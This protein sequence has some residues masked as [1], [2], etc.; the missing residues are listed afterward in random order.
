SVL[1]VCDHTTI[2]KWTRGKNIESINER[3][4]ITQSEP[5]SPLSNIH[6][7]QRLSSR[8]S[9]SSPSAVDV[10]SGNCALHQ[11]RKILSIHRA[12]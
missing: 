3:G 2:S 5:S 7:R 1:L 11:T 9:S 6:H 8:P 10:P 12:C 4:W